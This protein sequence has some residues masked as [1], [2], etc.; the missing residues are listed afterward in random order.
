MLMERVPGNPRDRILEVIA[1]GTNVDALAA[2]LI[3]CHLKAHPG[4]DV[5]AQAA[6]IPDSTE[7]DRAVRELMPLCEAT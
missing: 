5:Y 6:V 7:R 3:A 2:D 1:T 4:L